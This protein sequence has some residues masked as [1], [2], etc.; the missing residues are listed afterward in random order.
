MKDGVKIPEVVFKTRVRDDSLGSDNPF[1]WMDV[2]SQRLFCGLRT[3]VF[4]LPG[5]FT[6]TC[7]TFQ[8][9]GFEANYKKIRDLGVDEIYV[10]SVNDAFV[11][12][13]WLESQN[14]LNIKAIPDG[15]GEFTR[16]LGM[17][18]AK[19]NVG[20]GLRSW[21]YAAVIRNGIIEKWF[22]EPGRQDNFAGDPYGETSPDNIIGYLESVR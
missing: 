9:P 3:I 21:R 11:M 5:A 16:Q 22:E 6:P 8:L 7:S 12:N 14:V 18:V 10:A 2:P 13:K 4:S 1:R 19:D 15:T 17:L 20:F